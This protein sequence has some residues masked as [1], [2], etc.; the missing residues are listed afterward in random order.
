M[1]LRSRKPKIKKNKKN[2]IIHFH[3]NFTAIINNLAADHNLINKQGP[4]N[5]VLRKRTPQGKK[6][7]KVTAKNKKK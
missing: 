1:K 4:E 3:I 7:Y 5:T 2:A 6:F